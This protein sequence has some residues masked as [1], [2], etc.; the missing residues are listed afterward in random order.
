MLTAVALLFQYAV[1]QEGAA[2]AVEKLQLTQILVVSVGP[3]PARRFGDKGQMLLPSS[4]ETPP[5]ILYFK[6]KS[7]TDKKPDWQAFNVPFNNPSALKTIAPEKELV[8]HR[9]NKESGDYEKYVVIPPGD[10]GSRR[11]FF[12]IPSTTGMNLWDKQPLVRT[13]DLNAKSL[14]GKQFIL[15]NLSG[16]TVLHAFEDSVTAVPSMKTISYTRPK[17][18]EL[19]RL[20]A[21]YGTQ[22]K[23]IYNTAVRLDSRGNIQLF[24]LYNASPKTNSGRSVGVFRMM[25]PVTEH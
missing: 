7:A 15:K 5:A 14:Q 16:F 20:A 18:G 3:K 10:V 6:G 23:I 19:Y 2:K 8:L 12:L 25:I 13:I 4:G 11:V 24:A 1:A 22:K 21:R 17:S 9:K